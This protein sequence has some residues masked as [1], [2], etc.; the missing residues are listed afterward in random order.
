MIKIL[1]SDLELELSGSIAELQQIFE[2]I[3]ALVGGNETTLTH[4]ANSECDP[5][6]YTRALRELHIIRGSGPTKVSVENH[7]LVISAADENLQNFASWF[8][9]DSDAAPGS[10]NHFD[11]FPGDSCIDIDSRSLVIVVSSRPSDEH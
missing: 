10:H 9:F 3:H 6:P 11:Y 8:D 7:T 2:A 5:S 1:E 4:L